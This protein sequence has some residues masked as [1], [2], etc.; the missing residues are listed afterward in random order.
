VTFV[1]YKRAAAEN[2]GKHGP[3]DWK[4]SIAD[5]APTHSETLFMLGMKLIAED[6]YDRPGQ[7]GRYALWYWVDLLLSAKTPEAV[8]E[9]AVA[10]QASVETARR[11][12][13]A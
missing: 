6:R 12:V 2:P 3:L 8:V 9:I 1:S 7:L 4:V 13:P 10:C 5:V 11:K